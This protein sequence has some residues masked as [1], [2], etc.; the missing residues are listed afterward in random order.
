MF[1][2]QTIVKVSILAH[3]LYNVPLQLLAEIVAPIPTTAPEIYK[4]T[5]TSQSCSMHKKCKNKVQTERLIEAHKTT[6]ELPSMPK[7][8]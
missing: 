5:S 8:P 2:L 7:L 3:L 4:G 6:L 1:H